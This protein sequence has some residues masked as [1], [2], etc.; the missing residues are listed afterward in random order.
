MLLK[1]NLQEIDPKKYVGDYMASSIRS[2]DYK[3]N[4]WKMNKIKTCKIHLKLTWMI[5]FKDSFF[6][7]GCLFNCIY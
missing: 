3:I 7:E 2:C 5:K 6:Y 1:L 4:N